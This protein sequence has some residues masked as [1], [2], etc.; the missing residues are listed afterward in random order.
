MN[1]MNTND[2]N[3]SSL[4]AE[5]AANQPNVSTSSVSTSTFRRPDFRPST[6]HLS[7]G[8]SQSTDSSSSNQTYTQSSSIPAHVVK[9]INPFSSSLITCFD[10]IAKRVSLEGRS[11]RIALTFLEFMSLTQS[12]CT[13]R[14][15]AESKASQQA[16][17]TCCIYMATVVVA[18]ETLY[19]NLPADPLAPPLPT[20]THL[21]L[22]SNMKVD[23]F[24]HHL[25]HAYRHCIS[26]L[27]TH[28]TQPILDIRGIDRMEASVSSVQST[29]LR[30]IA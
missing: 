8:P 29:L 28:A 7:N 18:N 22:V 2:A 27:R 11:L 21:L 26:S 15:H 4:S 19:Q 10:V 12:A 16:W 23:E 30:A 17:S 9:H 13:D 24:L 25:Q 1:A 3:T 6:F 20:L 14:L 5:S